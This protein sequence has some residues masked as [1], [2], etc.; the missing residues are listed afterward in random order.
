MYMYRELKADVRKDL[1]PK[2]YSTIRVPMTDTQEK[3]YK[4]MEKEMIMH[5]QQ[6]MGEGKTLDSLVIAPNMLAQQMRLRQICLNPALIGG[7]NNSA[8]LSAL[9]ELLENFMEENRQVLVFT[10]FRQM[11]PYIEHILEK[12]DIPYDKI[13]G[14]MK[15][16][17]LKEV[18][19]RFRAGKSRIIVGTI[20]AMGEGL[21]LQEA[22]VAIFM[23][24]DW[25]PATNSQAEDRIHRGDISESPYIIKLYHPDT[26]ESDILLA[27]KLKEKIANR[28][29]GQVEMYRSM[30]SRHGLLREE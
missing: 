4:Q 5:V 30:L 14:G 6:E 27:C 12:Q 21:N 26:V 7:P 24:Q 22:S 10:M 28:T 18:E 2:L 15:L 17:E 25:V 16:Q 11:I 19:E 13:V 23:D 29:I 3:L 9:E 1:P 20:Q 8:K